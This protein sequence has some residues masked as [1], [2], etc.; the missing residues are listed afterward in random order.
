MVYYCGRSAERSFVSP[1]VV[2]IYYIGNL[3]M[4]FTVCYNELSYYLILNTISSFTK[5][6]QQAITVEMNETIV[7]NNKS[8]CF[9]YDKLI[10]FQLKGKRWTQLKKLWRL[11][12]AA[13]SALSSD[14]C[15]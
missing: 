6:L 1:N 12:F 4:N 7:S 13:W 10:I 2:L 9:N 15:R 3:L 14:R 8:E 5:K 11:V